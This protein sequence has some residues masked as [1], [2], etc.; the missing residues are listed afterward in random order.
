MNHT[1]NPCRNWLQ[2]RPCNSFALRAMI[3]RLLIA[4]FL[5]AVGNCGAAAEPL[6]PLP[7]A[8]QEQIAALEMQNQDMHRQIEA[9]KQQSKWASSSRQGG[10]SAS[11]PVVV[12]TNG[13]DAKASVQ[14][15]KWA[16]EAMNNR[17]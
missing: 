12:V 10:G 16:I 3:S 13:K 6:N 11:P 4:S 7:L 9:L 5:L 2:P 14:S 1:N 8:M 15:L 17:H